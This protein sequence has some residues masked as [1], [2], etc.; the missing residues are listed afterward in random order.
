IQVDMDAAHGWNEREK[1]K[2]TEST[3]SDE[4]NPSQSIIGSNIEGAGSEGI[5]ER[6]DDLSEG[7]EVPL[8]STKDPS[9]IKSISILFMPYLMQ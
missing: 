9:I 8:S 1:G 2:Y 6:E 3:G 4:E 5:R 7:S